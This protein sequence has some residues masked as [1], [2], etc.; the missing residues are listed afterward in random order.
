MIINRSAIIDRKNTG[1]VIRVGR[2]ARFV[3]SENAIAAIVALRRAK[4]YVVA[5]TIIAVSGVIKQP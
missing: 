4:L 3:T 5:I 1:I 2:A